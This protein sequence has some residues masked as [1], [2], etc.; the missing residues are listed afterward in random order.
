MVGG[1]EVD[2]AGG[3]VELLVALRPHLEAQRVLG[4]VHNQAEPLGTRSSKIVWSFLITKNRCRRRFCL[5]R[6]LDS[7]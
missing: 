2:G 7:G 1:G 6:Y 5:D 4:L 3:R